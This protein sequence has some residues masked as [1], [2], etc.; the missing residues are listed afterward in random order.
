MLSYGAE[1][2]H[3]TVIRLLLNKGAD[4]GKMGKGDRTALSSATA[5]GYKAVVRLLLDKGFDA[6]VIPHKVEVEFIR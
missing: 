2:R 4:T 6:G 5:N 1:N 3:E